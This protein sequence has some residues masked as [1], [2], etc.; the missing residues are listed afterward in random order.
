MRLQE[1]LTP[2]LM[3]LMLSLIGA[4]KEPVISSLTKFYAQILAF[5]ATSKMED[6][7]W[8]DVHRCLD[9]HMSLL[10]T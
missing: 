8:P 5:L 9:H 3:H 4:Q 6:S 10:R 7:R 1:D 2:E